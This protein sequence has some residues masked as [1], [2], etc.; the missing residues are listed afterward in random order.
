MVGM[1][2]HIEAF[3]HREK[4]PGPRKDKSAAL[5]EIPQ[6]L[7]GRKLRDY[8]VWKKGKVALLHTGKAAVTCRL[9]GL[10]LMIKLCKVCSNS[11]ALLVKSCVC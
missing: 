10:K 11:A 3:K 4:A 7:N 2:S 9:Q 5:D 6:F 1:Q 8:Q